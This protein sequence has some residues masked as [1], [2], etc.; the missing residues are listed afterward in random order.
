MSVAS[1]QDC[2]PSG[3]DTTPTECFQTQT[4]QVL[5]NH[6]PQNSEKAWRQRENMLP[7]EER[8][9]GNHAVPLCCTEHRLP[10]MSAYLQVKLVN[11]R[12]D[13]PG[14]SHESQKTPTPGSGGQSEPLLVTDLSKHRRVIYVIQGLQFPL[15]GKLARL[16]TCSVATLPAL[17]GAQISVSH[18]HAAPTLGPNPDALCSP[19]LEASVPGHREFVVLGIVSMHFF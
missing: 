17:S 19:H 13:A 10:R 11:I 7:G 9:P 6:G 5:T 16:A 1:K 18:Y 2:G 4:R 3:E 8:W 14:A 12:A 15:G